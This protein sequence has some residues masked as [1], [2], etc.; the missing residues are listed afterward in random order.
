MF[1]Y[2]WVGSNITKTIMRTEIQKAYIKK[3]TDLNDQFCFYLFNR[4]ELNL[5]LKTIDPAK[6]ELF[7]TEVFDENDYSKKIHVTLK[8]LPDFQAEHESINFGAYFSMSYEILAAYMEEVPEIINKI[9]GVSLS[10]NEK[11]AIPESENKLKAAI[12]KCN[13]GLPTQE[14][15]DTIAY[16]RLR[17]NYFT[18][19]LD[20]LNAPFLDIVNNKGTTLNLFWAT[21]SELDF[22]DQTVNEYSE[23]ETIDLIKIIKITLKDID[24]FI[25]NILDKKVIATNVTK[26]LFEA[27]PTRI[28]MYVVKMR[29]SKVAAVAKKKYGINLTDS[30][31][32]EAVKSI[33][34]R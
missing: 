22:T 18:H 6:K 7:T 17:R 30:D 2:L 10:L 31:M 12:A 23:S 4:E 26:E 29:K 11:R 15:F 19:I 5:K 25:A 34:K 21:R 9:N 3:L 1:A 13:R 32:D 14:L 33:G 24:T 27:N 8:K 16:C 28:N 20:T